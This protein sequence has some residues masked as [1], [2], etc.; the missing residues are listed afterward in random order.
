M[1]IVLLSY[2]ALQLDRAGSE[3]SNENHTP[4]IYHQYA[5]S[6]IAPPTELLSFQPDDEQR[7]HHD[8][9]EKT[10]HRRKL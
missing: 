6:S 5:W 4:S 7:V 3:S 1:K 8:T 9:K 2:A 10:A